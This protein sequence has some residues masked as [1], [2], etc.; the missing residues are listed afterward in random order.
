[1]TLSIIIPCRDD[2]AQLTA[3]IDSLLLSLSGTV[4]I[5]VIVVDDYSSVPVKTVAGVN[6]VRN[7]HHCGVSPSRH[8]GAL[9]ASC[10]WLLFVD[11]HMRFSRGWL[12][13]A[14]PALEASGSH[15]TLFCGSCLGLTDKP[16]G[17]DLDKHQ[18]KYWGATFI[19][20]GQHPH[21][22]K[23][24]RRV[25]EAIWHDPIEG[26]SPEIPCVMGA[27]YFIR[28]D[29][30][31]YLD[32]LRFLV[33]WGLEEEMLSLKTWLAGGEVRLLPRVEIGHVFPTISRKIPTRTVLRNRLFSIRTIL[34]AEMAE[35]LIGQLPNS[36]DFRLADK[37]LRADWYLV[38][39]ER[40]RNRMLFTRDFNWFCDKFGLSYPKD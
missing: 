21:S 25:F 35:A 12:D 7:E 38:E 22:Q 9:H 18:A 2:Q 8:I 1:M 14:M 26:E 32:P 3:T 27:C 4:Q 20:V 19:A 24:D 31:F 34:P 29:W 5:Q 16:G 40:H 28:R 39:S 13:R 15:R 10:D 17:D 23:P 33:H 30:Y 6:V 36:A 11:S 37:L